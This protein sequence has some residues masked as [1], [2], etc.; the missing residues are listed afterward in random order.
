M[1]PDQGLDDGQAETALAAGVP[2]LLESVEQPGQLGLGDAGTVIL[3]LEPGV[4][5][6]LERPES[7]LAPLR[8]DPEGV[9]EEVGDDLGQAV[10]VGLEG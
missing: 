10:G 4:I 5:A 8:G 2:A 7:D 1:E 3:D 6:V 9:V